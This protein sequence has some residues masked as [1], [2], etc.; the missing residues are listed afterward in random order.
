MAPESGQSNG[1]LVESQL[2]GGFGL[3]GAKFGFASPFL[4]ALQ[5]LLD[6]AKLVLVHLINH[7]LFVMGS[8]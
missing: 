3:I 6:L 4:G 7:L 1:I 2:T 5:G 8:V